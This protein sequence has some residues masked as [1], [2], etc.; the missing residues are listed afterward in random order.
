MNADPEINFPLDLNEATQEELEALPGI[1]PGKAEE[2]LA[3]R[4]A[5]GPFVSIEDL[6]EVDGIGQK[7]LDSLRDFLIIKP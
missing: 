4:D 3:Y 6:L 5:F 2:I 1:G 7:T